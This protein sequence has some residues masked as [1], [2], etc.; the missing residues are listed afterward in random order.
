MSLEETMFY[1]IEFIDE[2]KV[3][4][5]E[6]ILDKIEYNN[7]Q[8]TLLLILVK[9]LLEDT[10]YVCE[11]YKTLKKFIDI[12][13]QK[14]TPTNLIDILGIIKI[15]INKVC[16]GTKEEEKILNK[17]QLYDNIINQKEKTITLV[18]S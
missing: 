1:K 13:P 2:N 7:S 15:F 3:I 5:K 6:N 18:M 12:M 10:E 14:N 8:S 4:I 9:Y 16:P 11:E 17:L